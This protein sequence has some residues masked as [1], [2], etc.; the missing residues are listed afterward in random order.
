M[1]L[2]FSLN[3]LSS[4]FLRGLRMSEFAKAPNPSSPSSSSSRQ[5]KVDGSHAP[6]T[7]T[8]G[9]GNNAA[10]SSVAASVSPDNGAENAK[11]GAAVVSW[12]I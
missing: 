7:T 10:S 9:E 3:F 8:T 12:Q 2:Q 4:T 6:Q 1:S 11:G 5:S